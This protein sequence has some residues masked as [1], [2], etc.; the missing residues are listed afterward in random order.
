M[1]LSCAFIHAQTYNHLEGLNGCKDGASVHTGLTVPSNSM[2]VD[3]VFFFLYYLFIYLFCSFMVY[4]MML[5]L[6]QTM[7]CH[8]VGCMVSDE[9]E[10]MWK[11]LAIV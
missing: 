9:L 3:N 11:E 7:S 10:R 6:S 8:V 5:S 1:L 4:F 2:L